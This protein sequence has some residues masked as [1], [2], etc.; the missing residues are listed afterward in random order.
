VPALLIKK[1][2]DNPPFWPGDNSFIE[3]MEAIYEQVRIKNK[4]SL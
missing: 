3:A 2:G 4:K 1:Q